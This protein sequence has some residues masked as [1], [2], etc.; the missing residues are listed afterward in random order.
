MAS[1]PSLTAI[2]HQP[3]PNWVTPAWMKSSFILATPPRSLSILAFSL[4]GI[5]SPPPFGFIHFQKC[6]MVVVL[7]GIV[8]EAGVLAERAL[9]DLFERL[10]FQPGAFE[11]LVAVVDIG[12]VVLVVVIFERLARHVGRQRVVGIGQV[13]QLERHQVLLGPQ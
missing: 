12:L 13:G 11:Q 4:P 3:E 6:S 2:Q 10:A 5:L 8:E 9:D 7:A 1:L